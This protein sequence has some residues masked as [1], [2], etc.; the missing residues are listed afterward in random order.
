MGWRM[1]NFTILGVQGKIWFLE[2]DPEKQIY[3]GI[4]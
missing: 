2:E 3:G 4:A 1:E